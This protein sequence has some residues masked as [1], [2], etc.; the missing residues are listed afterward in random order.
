MAD[1]PAREGR[2]GLGGDL[3]AFF[4]LGPAV[5]GQKSHE[6]CRTMAG[7]HVDLVAQLAGEAE[8]EEPRREP[9]PCTR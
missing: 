7:R 3:R 5:L 4:E 2:F 6:E 8:T 9:R 1:H